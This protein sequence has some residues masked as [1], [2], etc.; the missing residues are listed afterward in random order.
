MS[1]F[2]IRLQDLKQLTKIVL[3]L[4]AFKVM[5]K[6]E[7]HDLLEAKEPLSVFFAS[8]GQT[9]ESS[10]GEDQNR[11]ANH[12]QA[13]ISG[14]EKWTPISESP[15]SIIKIHIVIGLIILHCSPIVYVH[16]S[17]RESR[18]YIR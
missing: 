13:A 1:Q 3:K 7:E 4:A 5:C 9:Y 11:M 18:P 12:L 15:P 17:C 10:S 14:F 16:V 2:P 6:S 8:C